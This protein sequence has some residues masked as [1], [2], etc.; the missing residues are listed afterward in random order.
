[1]HASHASAD[2]VRIARAACIASS[3]GR[4]SLS[5]LSSSSARAGAVGS[6]GSANVRGD[7]TIRRSL[8]SGASHDLHRPG[9]GGR[10]RGVVCAFTVARGAVGQEALATSD[11]NDGMAVIAGAGAAPFI[12][13]GTRGGSSSSAGSGGEGDGSLSRTWTCIPPCGRLPSV[14]K[15]LGGLLDCST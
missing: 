3:C 14:R 8:A 5:I 1:M 15:L 6:D 2:G 10:S 13:H 11:G 9:L 7:R 12:H 4:S